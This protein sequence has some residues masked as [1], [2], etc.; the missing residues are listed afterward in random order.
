[1]N[2]FRNDGEHR[3]GPGMAS[4]I[5]I[6][7][8]LCMATL[9]MLA[10]ASARSDEQLSQRSGAATEAYYAA[11][12]AM[13]RAIF[14]LD[15]ELCTA[16]EQ[17]VGEPEAYA[18][19]VLAIQGGAVRSVEEEEDGIRIELAVPIAE[20]KYLTAT[21]LAASRLEGP[22]YRVRSYRTVDE[23]PWEIDDDLPLYG[24][25]FGEGLGEEFGEE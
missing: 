9:A 20:E 13:Q 11:D 22:R 4:M 6:L 1:M 10:Y 25:D 8:A 17:L 7:V 5:M 14:A 19:R 12:A 15:T 16:R 21:L 18:Q 3:V 23:A 2:S 24:E